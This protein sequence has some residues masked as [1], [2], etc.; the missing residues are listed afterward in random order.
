MLYL[1][2]LGWASFGGHS[3]S[4]SARNGWAGCGVAVGVGRVPAGCSGSRH[5]AFG[6]HVVERRDGESRGP[7]GPGC[8]F[9][10]TTENFR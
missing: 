4:G 2:R 7:T 3:E 8:Y 10:N 5:G 9:I 6:G 1:S